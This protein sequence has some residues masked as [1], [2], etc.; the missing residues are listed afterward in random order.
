MHTR[1]P[2]G[3]NW[4]ER[5]RECVYSPALPESSRSIRPFQSPSLLISGSCNWR[6]LAHFCSRKHQKIYHSRFALVKKFQR[7]DSEASLKTLTWPH[8]F[9]DKTTKFSRLRLELK[10]NQTKYWD[11]ARKP[12]EWAFFPSNL[13]AFSSLLFSFCPAPLCLKW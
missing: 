2:D 3:G 10:E 6:S 12:R 11:M 8:G 5:G 7:S 13:Y 9:R 4:G 1:C